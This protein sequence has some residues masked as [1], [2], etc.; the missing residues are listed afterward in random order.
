[1]PTMRGKGC[2]VTEFGIVGIVAFVLFAPTLA[3]AALVWYLFSRRKADAKA[4]GIDVPAGWLADPTGRHEQRY[5]DGSAWTKHV[6][7]GGVQS[8]EGGQ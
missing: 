3:G 5:W 2:T 4:P 6:F 1:M 8:E 7:D